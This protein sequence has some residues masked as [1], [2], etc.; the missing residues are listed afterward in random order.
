[1][2]QIDVRNS[3]TAELADTHPGMKEDVEDLVV[4]AVHIIVVAKLEEFPHLV[5]RDSLTSNAI[6]YHH[7]GKFK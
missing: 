1:M 5:F 3:K 4:L 6:V 7:S 2:L